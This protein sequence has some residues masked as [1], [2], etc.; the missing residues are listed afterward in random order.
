[1]PFLV[2][3][4]SPPYATDAQTAAG[5]ATDLSVTPANIES[6]IIGKTEVVV[7]AGDSILLEDATDSALKRDTVQGVLDLVSVN[8]GNWSG[9]DLSVANGGTGGSTAS[10]ARSNLGAA[11]LGSNSDITALTGL[12]TDLSVAQ[13]GTGASTHTAN[14][15]L[16]GAGTSAI[17]SVA[18]STSGNV[19]TSNGTS[20][21]SAAAGG[22]FSA[23]YIST[24]QTFTADSVLTL[25]HGLGARPSVVEL[26]LK[27][28]TANKGY[29]VGDFIGYP[30]DTAGID[31]GF[32]IQV[33]ATNVE[34]IT[35]TGIRALDQ[36]T[37]N[38]TSL[39]TSS[40]TIYVVAYLGG[41]LS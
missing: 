35:G 12:T 30:Q 18:P 26:W 13:G 5:T 10:A 19:L 24:G 40:W 33:D 17:T 8:N 20:W 16:V 38:E 9:T 29:A 3:G 7:A 2:Q 4:G 28:G 21:T 27:C 31:A 15:V 11:A 32:V 39:T 41:T 34:L 22:I 1:M 37:F 23:E 6:L 14:S 25:A 36:S